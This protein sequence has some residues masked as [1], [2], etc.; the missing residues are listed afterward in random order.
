MK[1]LGTL[2]VLSHHMKKHRLISIEGKMQGMFAMKKLE[3][4][5]EELYKKIKNANAKIVF[6]DTDKKDFKNATL[7]HISEGE[8]S[9]NSTKI[10][11]LAKI[12]DWLK[13]M[14]LPG[15][16]PT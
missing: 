4:L 15:R 13:I 12:K 10:D 11:H 2:S 14:G 3:S 8:L 1:S 9:M 7:C 16:I 5:G 6:T